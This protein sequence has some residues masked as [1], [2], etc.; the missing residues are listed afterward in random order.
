VIARLRLPRV[1]IA[2][3]SRVRVLC[4]MIVRALS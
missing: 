4:A 3:T 1:H 2:L